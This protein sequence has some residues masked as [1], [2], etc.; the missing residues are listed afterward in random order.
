MPHLKFLILALSTNFCPIK[1]DLSGNT[2]WPQASSFQNFIF[3][4]A[5]EQQQRPL[6]F[7]AEREKDVET[8]IDSKS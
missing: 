6:V 5:V 2:V 8:H 7:I 1:I 4:E 3:V